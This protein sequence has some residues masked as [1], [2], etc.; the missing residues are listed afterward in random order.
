MDFVKIKNNFEEIEL[1]TNFKN[2]SFA[3]KQE[4]DSIIELP[5]KTDF[6]EKICDKLETKNKS[7]NK[8]TERLDKEVD[9]SKSKD[10]KVNSFLQN[11]SVI[12][13][14]EE[15]EISENKISSFNQEAELVKDKSSKN[16]ELLVT[17]L[18]R[19]RSFIVLMED[20]DFN[21]E[22]EDSLS[23]DSNDLEKLKTANS[24]Y[25]QTDVTG[26]FD[27][28]SDGSYVID[29]KVTKWKGKN[30]DL[31]NND[32]QYLP[33]TINVLENESEINSQMKIE[34]ISK[35]KREN[36]SKIS[37]NFNKRMKNLSEPNKAN[38]NEKMKNT[39]VGFSEKVKSK[40]RAFKK[41]QESTSK[42]KYELLDKLKSLKQDIEKSKI[43]NSLSSDFKQS[44][45]PI[46]LQKQMNK[47]SKKLN[48]LKSK[49][50]NSDFSEKNKQQDDD[51]LSVEE[52][53]LKEQPAEVE[54]ISNKK[55]EI[56]KW[57]LWSS[58][59][60]KPK[61]CFKSFLQ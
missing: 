42:D 54:T 46:T 61:V 55:Q 24:E 38:L 47:K 23:H 29:G 39:K 26:N 32:I 4:D 28:N 41:L 15:N 20:D 49:D 30:A 27:Y 17:S 44:E 2:E 57:K 45:K 31:G 19:N 9:E 60:S 43:N 14:K 22:I 40:E 48:L 35:P 11:K 21:I 18:E 16:N 12:D 1:E 33:K 3:D 53:D 52:V 6:H 7:E 37:S 36:L 8:Q 34:I 58:K 50:I 56:S 25:K 5:S 51:D 59:K 13:I 10:L